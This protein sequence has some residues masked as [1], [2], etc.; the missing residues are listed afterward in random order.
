[1]MELR[2]ASQ[3]GV[4]RLPWLDSR[5]SFSFGEYHDPKHLGFSVLRRGLDGQYGAFA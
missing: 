1:M 5:H 4:T 3:R 2:K